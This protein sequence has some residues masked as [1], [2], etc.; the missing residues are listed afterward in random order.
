MENSEVDPT[1]SRDERGYVRLSIIAESLLMSLLGRRCYPIHG[2]WLKPVRWN[3]ILRRL[4]GVLERSVDLSVD[5]DLAH[6]AVKRVKSTL[7][8]CSPMLEKGKRK[9]RCRRQGVAMDEL[10]RARRGISNEPRN[11]AIYLLRSLQG[12]NLEE[13]G[14]EFNITRFSSV[15]SV[16]ERM[17][18][19]ISVDR[20]LRNCVE[21]IK[22]AL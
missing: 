13:I 9:A 22:S 11:V 12:D 19:K 21:E 3:K 16:V 18:G 10:H 1:S 14:R 4:I 2:A 7:D 15:S 6:Q 5:T 8:S 20:Q 17:R